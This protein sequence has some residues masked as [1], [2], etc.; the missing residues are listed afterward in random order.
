MEK[1]RLDMQSLEAAEL[2]ELSGTLLWQYRLIDAFWFLNVEN[3]YG[4]AEAERIN[5]AV[6]GKVGRLAARDIKERF[7]IRAGGIQGFVQAMRYY[8]WYL[9]GSF[10]MEEKGEELE[11][12][13]AS[14]P[15]QI[16]R[17]KHGLG[18]YACKE[19]HRLEF[20]SFAGEIDPDLRVR[21]LFAPPDPHPDDLFCKWRISLES[22][23][24]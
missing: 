8:P 17:L 7:Q 24:E 20:T 16:G 19:M 11:I 13:S 21:C 3:D 10:E 18:E 9:M 14:C 4:A 1:G 5:A 2:R 6:W 22:A 23:G 15:A 12:V